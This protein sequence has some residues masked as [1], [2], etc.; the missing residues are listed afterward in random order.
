[1]ANP[2]QE[3]TKEETSEEKVSEQYILNNWKPSI[4][5]HHNKKEWFRDVGWDIHRIEQSEWGFNLFKKWVK[6]KHPVTK[7]PVYVPNHI[8]EPD[9]I[10]YFII[11]QYHPL[12][13]WDRT[14]A[15]G[16]WR[17][18][19]V[20]SVYLPD[21]KDFVFAVYKRITG[22]TYKKS[23]ASNIF[24]NIEFGRI[25]LRDSF[26][27]SPGYIPVKNGIVKINQQGN[28]IT[29]KL[30]ENSPNH[31]VTNRLPVVFNSEA[32]SKK[33]DDYI[34]SIFHWSNITT[35]Q[36]FAGYSLY[37]AM[38]YHKGMIFFGPTGSGKGTFFKIIQGMIGEDS[39]TSIPFQELVKPEQRARIYQKKVNIYA[40]LPNLVFK[41]ASYIKEILAGDRISA[42]LL[43]ENAFDFKPFTK[44]WGSCNTLPKVYDDDKAWWTRWLLVSVNKVDF[45][46]VDSSKKIPE[47]EKIFLNDEYEMS[48]ILNW[49]L[50]GLASLLREGE[51]T[52][53]IGWE[54][55]R[56][57]W[58]SQSDPVSSFVYDIEWIE[59]GGESETPKDELYLH[60]RKYCEYKGFS[61]TGEQQFKSEVS[62]RYTGTDKPLMNTRPVIG[63]SQV[64]CWKGIRMVDRTPDFGDN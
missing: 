59:L 58:L 20:R 12:T 22:D 3:E 26:V 24:N 53:D 9:F 17:Y 41:S 21:L 54:L 38:P 57:L 36:Q 6:V 45:R 19:P 50:E 15:N 23:E 25:V 63:G 62:R 7:K 33:W 43:Y 35:I 44:M 4:P 28:E 64:Y 49:A 16:S 31:Y 11:G 52:N 37:T 14:G 46:D 39:C 60:F 30:L 5:P 18:D 55:T 42:R 47:Y 51:F 40:D 1:M 34:R 32:K 10:Q 2:D 61:P 56:E 48:A 29:W 27:L 8:P 13:I